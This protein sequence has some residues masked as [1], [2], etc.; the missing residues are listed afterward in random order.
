MPLPSNPSERESRDSEI[1]RQA[2]RDREYERAWNS[3]PESFKKK[4]MEL[5]LK[6]DRD[7]EAAAMEFHE[8]WQTS[9][10][11]PDMAETLDTHVD[12]LIES[13]GNEA[14]IRAIVGDLQ[15]VMEKEFMDNKAQTV[16]GIACYLIKAPDASLKIR[17]HAIL[18]SIPRLAL[19]NGFKS[20]RDSAR[21]CGVSPQAMKNGRDRICEKLGLPIPVEG[22]KT[23]E[24]KQAYSE[25]ATRDHWRDRKFSHST[26]P[27]STLCK[28]KP[29]PPSN[30]VLKN[31]P[32]L[33]AA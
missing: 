4:A 27:D 21:E 25:V 2:Q 32:H 17:I 1:A 33:Q 5:G 29:K 6:P 13:Y 28:P 16:A 14:L 3:A 23:E 31:P 24:A 26:Q 20:M 9:S 15:I 30:P 18:H 7:R 22:S 11:E 10:Y 19:I 8:D 12:R